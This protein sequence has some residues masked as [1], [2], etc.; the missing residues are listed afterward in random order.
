MTE[1]QR[2]VL[3]INTCIFGKRMTDA[4][5]DIQLSEI[6]NGHDKRLIDQERKRIA[7]LVALTF[8]VAGQSVQAI[9]YKSGD[10]AR[11]QQMIMADIAGRE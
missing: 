3:A 9:G 4:K 2:T 8:M 7:R 5:A 6:V 1:T 10:L 11:T